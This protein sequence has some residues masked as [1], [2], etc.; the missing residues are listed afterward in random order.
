MAET[1]KFD[2][3]EER[4]ATGHEHMCA[5][6]SEGFCPNHLTRLET[7]LGYVGCCRACGQQYRVNA[8]AGTWTILR[9][10]DHYTGELLLKE[11]NGS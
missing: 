6:I 5:A 8:T 11:D 4:R 3:E 10:Y 9:M 2:T 7:I 1:V